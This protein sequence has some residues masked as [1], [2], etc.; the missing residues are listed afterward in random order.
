LTISALER[1]TG[2]PRSTI[3][4][5]V[6]EGL[7]PA[8]QKT[9]ASR[10]LYSEDH[11]RLLHQITELKSAGRSLAEIKAELEAELSQAH[12]NGV[13]LA[14][15]EYERI[16]REILRVATESFAQKGYDR[17]HV[18]DIVKAVG[19]T[20]QVFYS[21][22]PSKL[23]LLVESFTTFIGWNL[24][25]IEPRL[26]AAEDVGER[27][28]WRLLADERANQFGSDV[29]DQIRSLPGGSQEDKRRLAEKAWEGVVGYVKAEFVQTRPPD[30]PPPPISLDLLVYSLLGAHHNASAHA[31]WDGT[32][33][34]ADV[35]RVHL[36]LWLAVIAA[37]SGEVDIDSRIAR[38]ESLIQE[39][40]SRKAETP[41]APRE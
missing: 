33:T 8:P 12:A 32:S 13:D 18:A 3:H 34:K 10:A 5:Y 26:A 31:S 35:L 19:I 41:P 23:Q 40:A 27:L 22:F 6:R 2:V 1:E 28:L 25:F 11:V 14:G 15:R 29:L 9:A 30:S 17:T 20:H 16:H 38:Y 39:V 4:F 7:L 24:A 36:W 37:L 21:H